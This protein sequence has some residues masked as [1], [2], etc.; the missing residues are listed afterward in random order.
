MN[1]C[2]CFPALHCIACGVFTLLS[3]DLLF[4]PFFYDR[5][6]KWATRIENII[7]RRHT[8]FCR[9]IQNSNQ[10]NEPWEVN[11]S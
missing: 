3:L 10:T 1:L 11:I 2:A 4:F 5:V 8:F 9:P 7:F 6:M